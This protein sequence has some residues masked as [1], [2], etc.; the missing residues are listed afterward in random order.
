MSSKAERTEPERSSAGVL[1]LVDDNPIRL[2]SMTVFLES[3][4][5]RVHTVVDSESALSL[6]SALDPDLV[7]SDVVMP[8]IDGFEL[9]R[10]IKRDPATATLPV[11]LY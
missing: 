7:V 6:I 8:G 5:Y 3:E 1:L 4:G 9:C 10:R 2:D 11:M